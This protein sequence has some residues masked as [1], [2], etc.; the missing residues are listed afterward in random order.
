MLHIIEPTLHSYAGHCHSLV[1]ALT[2]ALPGMPVTIWAGRGSRPFWSGPGELKPYFYRSLRRLQAFLLYRK[3]LQSEGKVLISTAG[4]SDFL[5]LDWI[6]SKPI[7]DGKVYLYVHW[8]GAKTHKAD[9]LRKI[10][11]HQ[12]GLEVLTTTETVAGFFKRLGF[13]ARA[14][15]YPV[16]TDQGFLAM[17][18]P[19]RRLVV[20]GAARMDKG[21]DRI[22]DLVEDL[23]LSDSQL[24]IVVQVSATHQDKH[25]ADIQAQI[26]RLHR[27]GYA[28]L[29]VLADTLTPQVYRALF[30]GGISV[31]PYAAD[32]F[33]DRV[34]GVTLDA[35]GAACPVI[36]T[37]NTWLA[38]TVEHY[39][40]GIAVNDLAPAG[41]RVAICAVLADYKAYADHAATAGQAVRAEHS[42][43]AM[44]DALFQSE[45]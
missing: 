38:R 4:T 28:H 31:Q 3:L 29:Q 14:V 21:F 13:R 11:A 35:L 12:P 32:V 25:P 6:A 18:R 15:P 23:K 1:D 7:P 20:A 24:P 8:V 34:S 19:F 17:P 36:V 22:V 33:Q 9:Q 27:I 42:A 10:A 45:Q 30:V 41:L 5:I 16:S 26:D 37:A 39:G 44:V 40:A 2:Q 43:T